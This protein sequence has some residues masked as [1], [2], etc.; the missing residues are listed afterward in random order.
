MKGYTWGLVIGMF[1][2]YNNFIYKM[3][4]KWDPHNL[5]SFLGAFLVLWAVSHAV[6]FI[7]LGLKKA[8]R[9]IKSLLFYP[10]EASSS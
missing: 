6:R 7:F 2:T 10:K 9:K 4:Q 8:L 3:D 5:G 1:F